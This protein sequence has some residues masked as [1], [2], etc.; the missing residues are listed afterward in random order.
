MLIRNMARYCIC[1]S[2]L[3]AGHKGGPSVIGRTSDVFGSIVVLNMF[4]NS[5][6]GNLKQPV[7]GLVNVALIVVIGVGLARGYE[8][9]MP[10]VTGPLAYGAPTYDFEIWLASALLNTTFPFLMFYAAFFGYWPLVR[11]RATPESARVSS[12]R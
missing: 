7:K 1:P 5:L 4:Q 3:E 12:T 2:E 8:A 10:R 6:A 11:T 9:L